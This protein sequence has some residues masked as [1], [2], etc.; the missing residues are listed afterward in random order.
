MHGDRELVRRKT[1]DH[2]TDEEITI[3][4]PPQHNPKTGDPNKRQRVDSPQVAAWKTRMQTDEA[5]EI[6]KRRGSTIETINGDLKEHRG[7]TRFRVRGRDRIRSV[8]LLSVLT[9]NLLRALV[10]APEVMLPS[11]A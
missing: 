6:Y 2:V 5:V 10:I 8:L 11:T 9:Y 4:A 1:I 7:L 3:Y